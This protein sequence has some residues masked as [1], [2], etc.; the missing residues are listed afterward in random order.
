[1]ENDTAGTQTCTDPAGLAET[2][3][4]AYL[5]AHLLAGDRERAE[6]AVLQAIEAWNAERHNEEELFEHVVRAAVRARGS[7]DPGG[8]D[9]SFLPAELRA[10]VNLPRELRH[11]FVLRMLAGLSQAD[12]ARMLRMSPKRVGQ[13]T[14][15]A[16]KRLP[17]LAEAAAAGVPYLTWKMRIEWAD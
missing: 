14:C 11:C 8:P 6:N 16:L 4:R 1:V 15:S 13:Y 2:I 17:A 9:A 10:V 3:D 7:A 12:C 5:T